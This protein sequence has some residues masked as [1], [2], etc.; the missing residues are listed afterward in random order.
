ML[1]LTLIGGFVLSLGAALGLIPLVR[2]IGLRLGWMDRPDGQRKV[3]VRPIP[4]VGGL[5][6]IAA[7]ALSAATLLLVRPWLPEAVG[8]ALS[9]PAWP[10][11][12]GAFL[13]ALVGFADD[14]RDL[15]A[16]PKLVAQTLIA[17]LVVAGGY[18]ITAF[19]AALGGGEIAFA[20][21]AL[22]TVVWVV[23]TING[24]N[25]IDG[26]DGLAG[27]VLTIAF[28]GLGAAFL[29]GGSPAGLLLA[30]TTVGAI[31]GFLRYNAAPASIFMGDVGS[32]FLGYTLAV[33]ALQGSAHADPVLALVIAASAM[34][35]PVL[36]GIVTT[37]RRPQ[38]D[39][40]LLHSDG[41]HVHHRLLLRYPKSTVVRILYALS[42][43]FALGAAAMAAS[44]KPIALA[45][46]GV[47]MLGVFGFLYWLGYL[48][49]RFAAG[50]ADRR[51]RPLPAE[52]V[53]ARSS[54]DGASLP[55]GSPVLQASRPPVNGAGVHAEAGPTQALSPAASPER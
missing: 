13:M 25:F 16:L 12:L 20:V 46:F 3:H 19:D 48:P 37:I 47:G 39:K 32:H 41:D 17:G 35:L 43:F 45:L 4:R 26:L 9:L 38:Y 29:L 30:V 36:D 24:V 14:V 10:V 22:L 42:A 8:A 28:V 50:P 2:R 51:L 40:P 18:R 34:G 52:L 49:G 54:G 31:V 23:G 27:G 11:L 55:V 33:F 53:D 21:S 44:P 7:V 5:A 15:N 6:I 1:V